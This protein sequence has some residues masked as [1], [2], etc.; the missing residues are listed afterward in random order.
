MKNLIL[1]LLLLSSFNLFSLNFDFEFTGFGQDIKTTFAVNQTDSWSYTKDDL[2]FEFTIS[3]VNVPTPYKVVHV[4]LSKNQKNHLQFIYQ[5]A[6]I[7]NDNV[8][9]T[10]NDLRMTITLSN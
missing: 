3:P 10:M 7:C 6:F 2:N 8:R 5:A 1:P 9:L 4:R